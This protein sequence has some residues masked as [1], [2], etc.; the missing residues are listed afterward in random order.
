MLNR[1]PL[2]IDGTA[3][4]HNDINVL[5]RAPLFIDVLKGTAPRV[6]F[7]VNGNQYDTGYYL[8]DRIYPEWAVCMKTIPRP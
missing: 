1:A 7:T 3:G 2:F 8:A 4:S 5:N 6:H